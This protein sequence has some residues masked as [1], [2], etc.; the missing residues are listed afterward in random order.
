MAGLRVH[1][2]IQDVHTTV[3]RLS[4]QSDA[5][6][7]HAEPHNDGSDMP[8]CVMRQSASTAEEQFQQ[9]PF[10]TSP[11]TYTHRRIS[12]PGIPGSV[13]LAQWQIEGREG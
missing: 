13:T 11:M 6:Q 3:T 2:N 9:V 8:T 12:D 1:I 7:R 10:L 4:V 5:F